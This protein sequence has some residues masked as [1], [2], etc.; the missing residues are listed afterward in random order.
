[1]RP[2]I[3]VMLPSANPILVSRAAIRPSIPNTIS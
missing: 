1:M 3:V 2:E